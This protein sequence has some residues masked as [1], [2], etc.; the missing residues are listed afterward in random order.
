MRLLA[1]LLLLPLAMTARDILVTDLVSLE[2]AVKAAQPG[3][4]IVLREGAW[5]DTVIKFKGQGTA[6][7]PITLRAAIPGKT[8][9]TGASGIRIGGEHLVVEGL[10]FQALDPSIGDSIEFRID[11]KNLARHCRMTQCAITLDPAIGSKTDEESRWVGIYGSENRVDHCLLQ[12]KLTKGTTLVV[13]LGDKNEGRHI[14]EQNYFGP[15]EKLGKNGGETIRIG[16]SKNSMQTAACVIRQNLFEKCNGEA[17]CISNKSCGNL[18]QANTFLEVSGTLTLRHGNGC[19]VENNTFFGN[20]AS[21]TGGIRII[22]EDHIVRGNYLE[23]LGGDDVRSGITFMMGLPDSPLNGYFQVKRAKVENNS[24]VDCKVPLLIALEG[25]KVPGKPTQPP[26]DC[27]ISGN[28]ISAAKA[29]I[30]DARCD[31]AG[32]TWQDNQFSGKE[33]GLPA[34]AGITFGAAPAITPLPAIPRSTVGPAWWK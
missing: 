30:V 33:L 1:S 10:W 7:A 5:A 11:S 21:G 17:E 26:V 13:W 6:A 20:H 2:A 15:R 32:L 31:L 18:Y 8:I 4:N 24:L 14:I 25:D 29:K 27:V 34:T 16:D 23:N 19:T 3:D 28:K 9:F 22:G 12:G